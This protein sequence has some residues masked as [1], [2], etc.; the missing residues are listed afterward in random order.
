MNM[1]K[2]LIG[3][4][5]AFLTI[6]SC[7]N[8]ILTDIEIKNSSGFRIDSLKIGQKDYFGGNY[9]SLEPEESAIYKSDL[10]DFS[11]DGSSHI[12][13]YWQNNKTVILPF[14]YYKDGSPTDKLLQIR[15]L[16]DSIKMNIKF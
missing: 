5:G 9:I 13:S 11:A 8:P 2:H 7:D 1:K 10:T 16:K 12:V 6:S 3:I 15:I 14:A 4:L